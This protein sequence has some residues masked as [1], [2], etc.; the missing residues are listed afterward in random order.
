MNAPPIAEFSKGS[1]HGAPGGPPVASDVICGT[2]GELALAQI[3]AAGVDCL[4]TN[5]GSHEVGLFDALIGPSAPHLIVGLHE[6]LVLSMAD[7]YHRLS[8]KPGLVIVHLIA[9]VAQLLGQLYN[10]YRDG[11][12]LVITAGMRD[13][14][15][16]NDDLPLAAPSGFGQKDVARPFAKA[17]WDARQAESLPLLLR[18]AFKVATTA[19]CG[20]VYLGMLS[21]ALEKKN[22]KAQILPAERFLLRSRPRPASSAVEAAAKLLSEAARPLLVVGD[23]VWKS[24]AQAELLLLSEQLGLPVAA[25]V[26]AQAEISAM[27]LPLASPFL[28]FHNFPSQHPHYLGNFRIDS[29][30]I[31]R[32][33][34]LVMCV[35]CRDFGDRELPDAPD[36]PSAPIV[37]MGVDTSA[38]GRAYPS[39]LALVGDVKEALSDLRAA[40][41]TVP[42][43]PKLAALAARRSAEISEFTAAQRARAEAVA[44]DNFGRSPMH[45]DEV[46][47]V[48]ARAL[49]PNAVVVNENPTARYGALAFGFRD[50]ERTFLGTS[51]IVL[52]W[53]IG[54]ATGAKLAAPD[55]QVVCSIGDGSLMYSAAGFWTQARYRI[56]VLTVVFNN[57]NYQTVRLVYHNYAGR[58]ASMGHYPATYLGDPDINFVKLAES[59]G[60]R[61]EGVATAGELAEALKRGMLANRDGRPYLVEVATARYGPGAESTWR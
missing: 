9:G 11:S 40:I 43:Q 28:A 42:S 59:Q 7:G 38:M 3:K 5:P 49:D 54:A 18:R 21:S 51:G 19:P 39:D 6:G 24:G 29:E 56:P 25:Q 12:A 27:G 57:R 8:G 22:V 26:S 2:G 41:G 50:G 13:N 1:E 60:V 30:W 53:G 23:E 47:E 44:H 36:A 33:V 45:P 32:G 55:R 37:R 10:A 16:W 58:M 52:G 48:M 14:E 35:G 34:D 4:F 31:R 20:P 61:G 15:V 46:V 17:C